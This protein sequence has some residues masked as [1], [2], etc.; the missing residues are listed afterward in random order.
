MTVASQIAA[1]R[2]HK[3][4]LGRAHNVLNRAIR[5]GQIKKPTSCSRCDRPTEPHNLHG[6]HEDYDAPLEVIWFCQWCHKLL[7]PASDNRKRPPKPATTIR[8]NLTH[9]RTH[10]KRPDG[11]CGLTQI[12]LAQRAGMKPNAVSAIETGVIEHPQRLTLARLAV[13]LDT[14][15]EILLGENEALSTTG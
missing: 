7:H 1:I 10:Y 8:E 4:R 5:S 11:L 14:T 6:H 15:V 9:A 13:A 12:E 2:Q 3:A